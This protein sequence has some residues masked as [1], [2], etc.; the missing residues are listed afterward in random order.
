MRE[1]PRSR[2]LI[3][4]NKCRVGR[5]HSRDFALRHDWHSLIG[6]DRSMCERSA[7]FYPDA[8]DYAAYLS[9]DVAAGLLGLRLRAWRHDA[10]RTRLKDEQKRSLENVVVVGAAEGSEAAWSVESALAD[11]ERRL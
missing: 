2:R 9:E 3:S 10:Y 11:V 4:H 6:A 5:G 7:A 8:D 1:Y